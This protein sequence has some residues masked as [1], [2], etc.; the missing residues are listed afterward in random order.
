[1]E[2]PTPITASVPAATAPAVAVIYDRRRELR[3][4]IR[5]L[6]DEA[7]IIRSEESRCR[8]SI[9]RTVKPEYAAQKL[10]LEASA[11]SLRNHRVGELRREA[12]YSLLAYAYIRGMAFRKTEP[13]SDAGKVCQ[14]KLGDLVRRFG[15]AG[16]ASG[17]NAWLLAAL[18]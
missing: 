4:K 8:A 11:S 12:R 10:Q 15:S 1:M 13:K 2:P 14:V 6:A 17:L 7:R 16:Q 5:S 3:V 9:A 18:A